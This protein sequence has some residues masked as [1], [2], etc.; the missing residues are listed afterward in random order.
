MRKKSR[1]NAT[2]EQKGLDKCYQRAYDCDIEAKQCNGR[3][4]NT[5]KTIQ[6]LARLLAQTDERELTFRF[7]R[8]EGE[9]ELFAKVAGLGK[10]RGQLRELGRILCFTDN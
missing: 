10:G 1:K 5:M 7:E 4:G 3:G 9:T 2:Q 8:A 6:K